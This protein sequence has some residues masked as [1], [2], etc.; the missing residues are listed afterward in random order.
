M[1]PE[2]TFIIWGKCGSLKGKREEKQT[3]NW[4]SSRSKQRTQ[5]YLLCRPSLYAA[6]LFCS[7][8]WD[9]VQVFAKARHQLCDGSADHISPRRVTWP[10]NL[11]Q[12]KKNQCY[13]QPRA[14]REKSAHIV[15]HTRSSLEKLNFCRLG[16]NVKTGEPKR[17]HPL[18]N[19]F[20]LF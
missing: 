17:G 20:F 12:G 15:S 19:K 14:L 13:Y 4:Q 9:F 8:Y 10:V 1:S 5:T 11:A 7:S 3:N 6:G 2:V 16:P 18:Q